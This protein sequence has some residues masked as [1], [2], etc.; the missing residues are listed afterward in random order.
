MHPQIFLKL[1]C[2]PKNENNRKINWGVFP[3][4]QHFKGKKGVLKFR[5]G[6]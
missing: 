6:D 4:L 5:N 2:E 3:S 1:K